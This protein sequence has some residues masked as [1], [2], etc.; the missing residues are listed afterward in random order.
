MGGGEIGS[1]AREEELDHSG[2][3]A[4]IDEG[5]RAQVA[6]PFH[7]TAQGYPAIEIAQ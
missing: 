2:A 5:E 3:I 4:Q 6:A 1:I 7:P